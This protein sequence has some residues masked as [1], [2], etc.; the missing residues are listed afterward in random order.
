MLKPP[1]VTCC[2]IADCDGAVESRFGPA[3]R[4]EPAAARVWQLPQPCAETPVAPFVGSPIN[5]SVAGGFAPPEPAPGVVVPGPLDVFAPLLPSQNT[6]S[7][8]LVAEGKNEL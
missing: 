1:F 6:V 2:T 3:V 5:V 8:S 4:L 7:L